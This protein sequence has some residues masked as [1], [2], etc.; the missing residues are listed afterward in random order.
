MESSAHEA[1][2]LLAAKARRGDA[3]A[4]REFQELAS[5]A[6]EADELLLLA[7][8]AKKAFAQ[9]VS[10]LPIVRIGL[11]G[12]C[13]FH[14]WKHLF[15]VRLLGEGVRP[16]FTEGLFDNYTAEI[17]E[18]GGI[19][20]GGQLDFV[21]LCPSAQRLMKPALA[22]GDSAVGREMTVASTREILALCRKA[23]ERTQAEIILVN[24]PLP[25]RQD[26]GSFRNR[27]LAT[28]WT[29]RRAVNL[30]LGLAAPAFVQLCDRE[31]LEA[32]LGLEKAEDRRGWFESKQPGS[33]ALL[34]VL[35]AEVARVVAQAR[36]PMK[37]V[38]ALDLDNTLWGGV[39]G[40]DG[41]AGIE[42]GDT[43][44]RGEAF[45]DFQKY[46]KSLKDRGVLLAVCSKNDEAKALEPL[47]K[48]PEMILKREDFVA[49]YANWEP[50]PENLRRMAAELRLGLDSFVFVDDNPAEIEIVRQF[51]PEVGRVLLG[52]DPA[53]Y[54]AQLQDSRFFEPRQITKEDGV[55]SE[56]YRAEAQRKGM[57]SQCSD[58]GSYLRS[59]EMVAEVQPFRLVDLPRITQL[60]TKSN[61][62]NVTTK[63][64]SEAEL[65]VISQD[66][67]WGHFSVRLKDRFGDHGLISVVILRFENG[68]AE[69]DTWLMSCRVLKRQ[70]EEVVLNE[71]FRQARARDCQ[72]VRGCYLPTEKNGIVKD[73]YSKFGFIRQEKRGAG[74]C[75]G[76]AIQDFRPLGHRINI[77]QDEP[78]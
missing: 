68:V 64:R 42:L 27:T 4:F 61:Q 18:P 22:D 30:E 13:T 33:P 59:L 31:Y 17:L 75:Y 52:P 39:I 49:F 2:R 34:A 7:N 50:K 24:F 32:R 65:T 41:L 23:H 25:C 9:E 77:R 46:I 10:N 63:R 70:V 56:Q 72:E 58:M 37:K 40:D 19:L 73:L 15:E 78:S 48:H 35:A 43:S 1:I 76:L 3:R 29:F 5:H 51:T 26:W 47:E 12:A 69:I 16:L 6:M 55:R 71:I 74:E 20:E 8:L 45:K 53:D 44:P 38:L 11:L 14:P 66:H 60:I 57:E 36:R 54:T 62:F 28:D 21:L 67:D